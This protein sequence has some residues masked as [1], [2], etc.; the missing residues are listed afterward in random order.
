MGQL[1]GPLLNLA[2]LLRRLNQSA[3]VIHQLLVDEQYEHQ[4][5]A[6]LPALELEELLAAYSGAPCR[7]LAGSS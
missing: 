2:L 6:V 5:M 4:R 3:S 1:M 7:M